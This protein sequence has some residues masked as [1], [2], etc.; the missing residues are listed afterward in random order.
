MAC[1]KYSTDDTQNHTC[2]LYKTIYCPVS[3]QRAGIR[4]D[5]WRT[6][7]S[8]Q[9]TALSVW[10]WEIIGMD[11][12]QTCQWTIYYLASGQKTHW[13]DRPCGT[14]SKDEGPEPWMVDTPEWILDQT[15]MNQTGGNKMVSQLYLTFDHYWV[16][17]GLHESSITKISV[18]KFAG[19]QFASMKWLHETGMNPDQ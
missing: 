8:K 18:I 9:W 10:T 3:E 5:T 12:E 7:L 13:L 14:E 4:I 2:T 19:D 6:D 16:R 11:V 17:L 15:E 1:H